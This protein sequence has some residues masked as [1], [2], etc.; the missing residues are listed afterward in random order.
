MEL[1]EDPDSTR[2]EILAAAYRSLCRHG[3]AD[4]TIE[5]IG[6][7][8]DKSI[9]LIYH[10][11]DGKDEL[12]LACL[13]FMLEQY[14]TETE[15]DESADP[16]A[17]LEALCDEGLF[18][19]SS[20]EDREFIRSLVELRGQAPHNPAFREHF[21]RSDAF[22]RIQLLEIIEAGIEDGTFHDVDADRTAEM[23]HTLV[24]GA[25]FR[26]ATAS[27]DEWRPVLRKELQAYL[28]TRLYR[29]SE[30]A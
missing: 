2:E 26:Y 27:D 14:R 25:F 23:I 22:F 16:R 15:S 20:S 9:S 8:F 28:E 7:E 10:H 12:L 21:T 29:P 5:K 17:E 6:E 30:T 3:Y 4:L 19:D 11:Y 24:S 18:L 1:F 13:D